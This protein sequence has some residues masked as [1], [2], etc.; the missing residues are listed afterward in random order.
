[1]NNPISRR[2]GAVAVTGGLALIGG[3][4][5]A[6]CG[7]STEPTPQTGTSTTTAPTTTGSTAPPPSVQPSEKN[8]DTRGG[9]LFTPDHKAQPAPTE[10]PGVHR[11]N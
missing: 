1:M 10:P 2:I 11:N 5:L 8:L 3:A 9:N 7:T 4:A 6:A